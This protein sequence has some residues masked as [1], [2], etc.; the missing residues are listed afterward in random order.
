MTT[1]LTV[2]DLRAA[3][4]ATEVLHGVSVEVPEKS[5]ACLLGPSGCGKTTL[6][7][8]VAGFHRPTRGRIELSGRTLDGGGAGVH[9]PAERRRIGY[10]PQNVALFPHL[11][12]AANIGFGL[13]RDKRAD[14]VARLL[15]LVDLTGYARRRP[16]QL[17]GGQQQR[18]ALARALAP[19][20]D[21]LLLDEPFTALDADLRARVRC[22]VADLLRRAGITAVLV[23]HDAQEALAFADTI[24]IL[25]AG[26]VI[27]SGTPDQLH[28]EP[29]TAAVARAL[30]D[31]NV[32]EAVLEGGHART[33]AG[34]LPLPISAT[35]PVGPAL[36]VLVRPRQIALSDAPTAVSIAAQIVRSEFRGED[37][38]LELTVSG[39]PQPIIAHTRQP[40]AHG[41]VTHLEING[42]A[43]PLAG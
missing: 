33:P 22:E 29:A 36:R 3:H 25:S 11:S 4:G 27:Q 5:L 6:L 42:N 32:F 2:T 14:A 24:S 34:L 9:V 16:H 15:D 18:V 41:T 21:L 20:P 17:S 13:P 30:G 10:I 1:G 43:Y 12:V 38:R 8:A 35:V 23:T 37:Y 19:E 39:C 31:A 28:T 7:R 40:L 26:Q